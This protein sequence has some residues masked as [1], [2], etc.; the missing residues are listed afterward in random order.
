MIT[1]F[2]FFNTKLDLS[3]DPSKDNFSLKLSSVPEEKN[4]GSEKISELSTLMDKF[5]SLLNKGKQQGL[6]S[7]DGNCYLE[8]K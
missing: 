2:S 8:K 3:Q 5:Y 4:Q 6:S 1:P 7:F